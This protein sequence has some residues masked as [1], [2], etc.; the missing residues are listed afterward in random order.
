MLGNI[1]EPMSLYGDFHKWGYPKSWMV[2]NGKSSVTATPTD[3]YALSANGM[4]RYPVSY[5][6]TRKIMLWE[7]DGDTMSALIEQMRETDCIKFTNQVIRMT[8]A[9]LSAPYFDPE[10]DPTGS[11]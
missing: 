4:K 10:T 7:S 11:Q 9:D 3:S 1:T 6:E 8:T 5:F 2:Y